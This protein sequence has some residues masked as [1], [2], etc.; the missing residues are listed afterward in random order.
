MSR[1]VS[2]VRMAL[3]A[4]ALAGA[5]PMQTRTIQLAELRDRIAGGW[6]GQMIG[7]SFAAPTEFLAQ[8]KPILGELPTWT[9]D[10][11]RRALDQDDLYVD[12]SLAKVLDEIGLDATTDDFARMLR[13]SKYRLWHANLAGRRNLRR[14][15]PA[16]MAGHPD[17]NAHAEDLDFQIEADF[18]GLM[19]PGLYRSATDLALR[20]GRVVSYGDGLHGGIFVSCMYAAAFVERNPRRVVERGWECLPPRSAYANLISDV[21][22]WT[23]AHPGDWKKTWQLIE[24]KWNKD[25]SCPAG[26]LRPFSI[27]AKLNGAYIALGL[28]HGGGD[29]GRT[30][31]ISTRS[32]QDSDC[33]AAASGGI[34]GVLLGCRR[35]PDAWKGGLD[36]IAE[37]KF[38]HTEFTFNTI[39]ESS[40]RRA[41]ALA[42]RQGGSVRDGHV[43]IRMQE[44]E[45]PA[46]A[47]WN[48]GQP[49]EWIPIHDS[50]WR[51]KGEWSTRPSTDP[52]APP[53]TETRR[54]VRRGSMAEITFRGTGAVISGAY[55]PDGGRAEVYLDGALHRRIDSCSDESRPRQNEAVWHAFNLPDG[56]HT[57][58]LG[59]AGEAFPGCAGAS[60]ELG[61][62]IVYQGGYRTAPPGGD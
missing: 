6:A 19:A 30:V 61:G 32:G 29:F 15:V 27:D 46:L 34:L 1:L 42:L 36:S 25:D 54:T 22:A 28:L 60:V 4:V 14:G 48:A 13:D 3:S 49:R 62:L 17:F 40:Y 2:L 51:W 20:A 7:V 57:V 44:P 26:A 39:V 12:M 10:L 53:G 47:S 18:I 56:L 9:P 31:E 38:N 52:E 16:A 37:V 33:N 59:A 24:N 21:L 35:I 11:V 45:P 50:R 23:R 58:R 55:L 43:T 5:A 8:G 41:L